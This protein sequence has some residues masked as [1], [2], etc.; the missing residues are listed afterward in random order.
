MKSIKFEVLAAKTIDSAE[1]NVVQ[2][3]PEIELT[4]GLSKKNKR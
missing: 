4:N 1:K 3:F 2:P